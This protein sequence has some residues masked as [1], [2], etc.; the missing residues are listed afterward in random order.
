MLKIIN[1]VN[2][3]QEFWAIIRIGVHILQAIWM[4]L[5]LQRI[6]GGWVNTVIILHIRAIKVLYVVIHKVLLT[7]CLI[8]ISWGVIITHVVI[9]V[10]KSWIRKVNSVVVSRWVIGSGVSKWIL[11]HFFILSGF[12]LLFH[13]LKKLLYHFILNLINN[14]RLVLCLVLYL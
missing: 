4:I 13:K 8:C 3:V 12:R 6:V 1:H 11:C 10:V 2:G 5:K 14:N 9:V 7:F